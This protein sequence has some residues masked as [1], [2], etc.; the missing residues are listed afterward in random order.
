MLTKPPTMLDKLI[1]SGHAVTRDFMTHASRKEVLTVTHLWQVR[2]RG[3]PLVQLLAQGGGQRRRV[4][5]QRG[6]LYRR[7]RA[8][9]AQHPVRVQV[10]EFQGSGFG[11]SRPQ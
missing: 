9:T 3:Q 4:P 1:H 11:L 8:R 7:R 6:C 5:V 2:R 10:S